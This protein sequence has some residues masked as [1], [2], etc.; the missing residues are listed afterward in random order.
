EATVPGVGVVRNTNRLLAEP[1]VVGLKTGSS[2]PAGGALMWAAHPASG[3]RSRLILGVV[4]R[5]GAG[6]PGLDAKLEAAFA[7]SRRL[8]EAARRLAP[9]GGA[10]ASSGH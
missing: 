6:G 8:L 1:G 7:S 9:G 5:Q 10:E 2:T 3:D 4:L